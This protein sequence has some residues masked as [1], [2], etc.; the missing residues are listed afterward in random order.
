MAAWKVHA[1]NGSKVDVNLEGARSAKEARERVAVAL[2]VDS[3]PLVGVKLLNGIVTVTDDTSLDSLDKQQG[4]CAI[5]VRGAPDWYPR[6]R[7]VHYDLEV[8]QITHQAGTYFAEYVNG[9]SEEVDEELYRR[10]L[11]TWNWQEVSKDGRTWA[12]PPEKPE[13]SPNWT[14]FLTSPG[15]RRTAVTGAGAVVGFLA[16]VTGN[17]PNG[18]IRLDGD[19]GNGF[20]VAQV[21]GLVIYGAVQ[22][23]SLFAKK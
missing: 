20:V 22:I 18:N 4:L 16:G 3:E 13:D 12:H 7:Y 23:A 9:T 8:L 5:L 2:G 15:V 14:T 6:E 21:I 19:F 1:F 10:A 11:G 17:V